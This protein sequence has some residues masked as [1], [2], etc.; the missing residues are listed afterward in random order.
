MNKVT[1]QQPLTV[2]TVTGPPPIRGRFLR[3]ADSWGVF[4]VGF[5][6]HLVQLRVCVYPPGVTDHERTMLRLWYSAPIWGV[7]GWLALWPAISAVSPVDPPFSILAA[8]AVMLSVVWVVGHQAWP[9]RK[10]VRSMVLW[11]DDDEDPTT[12][13]RADQLLRIVDSLRV[14]DRDLRE[15]R[16]DAVRHEAI[17]ARCYDDLA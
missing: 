15:G 3:G 4:R 14:A 8:A 10:S 12:R 2:A 17:W 13:R 11:I 6:R 7:I 16:I 1:G 9:V 5:A